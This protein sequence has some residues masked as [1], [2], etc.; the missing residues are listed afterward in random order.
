MKHAPAKK[1]PERA[2]HIEIPEHELEFEAV[3]SSGPGGQNVNKVSTKV[4]LRFAIGASAVLPG[5]VKARLRALAGAA[6][7]SDDVLHITSQRTRSQLQNRD[8]AREKLHALVTRALHV[9]R[10]RR[11]TKPTRASKR[12]R[13]D[14]KRHR[15]RTKAGRSK[16]DRD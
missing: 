8:D 2:R 16:V 10:P 11:A 14:D 5:P 3:R 12:R 9:P 15:S 6:V 7:D 13:M 4:V 1:Q